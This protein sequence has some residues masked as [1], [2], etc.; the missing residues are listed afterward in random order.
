MGDFGRVHFPQV[1]RNDYVNVSGKPFEQKEEDE[2]HQNTFCDG[3]RGFAAFQWASCRL[4]WLSRLPALWLSEAW[5][6]LKPHFDVHYGEV[7]S[8]RRRRFSV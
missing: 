1:E 4:D 3:L 5:E 2:I 6:P 7:Y 8:R